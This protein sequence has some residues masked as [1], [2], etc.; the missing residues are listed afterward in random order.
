M[1][2]AHRVIAPDS[3][4]I[5]TQRIKMR[6]L[7]D[8]AQDLLPP[9]GGIFL[10][11]DTQG[12]EKEVLRGATGLLSRIVA[13]QVEISLIPLYDG[14]PTLAAM[15]EYIETLGYEMFNLVPGFKDLNT[16]R[17]IQVDG[18]FVARDRSNALISRKV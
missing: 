9:H 6:R 1:H 13:M 14:A 12:Y 2:E 8:V 11:I 4:Y 18:L 15:V 17:V 10:K 3:A 5:A 7:D 16:G